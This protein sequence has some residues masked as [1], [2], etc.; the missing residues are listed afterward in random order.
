MDYRAPGAGLPIAVA[1]WC[2]GAMT[3]VLPLRGVWR[4]GLIG[5]ETYDSLAAAGL[6]DLP[7]LTTWTRRDLLALPELGPAAVARIEAVL[8]RHCLSLAPDRRRRFR[9]PRYRLDPY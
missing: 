1:P 6:R 3:A 8:A 9:R 7:E 5:K 2:N 4:A